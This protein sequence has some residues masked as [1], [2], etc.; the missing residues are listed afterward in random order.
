MKA[1]PKYVASRTLQASDMEWNSTLL[2]ADRMLDAI[3]ELRE[4]EGRDVTV[5]GSAT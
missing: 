4:R 5:G 3:D 1:L 2:P